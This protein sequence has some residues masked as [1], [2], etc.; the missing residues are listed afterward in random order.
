MCVCVLFKK[1]TIKEE[2][3]DLR[4]SKGD[5]ERAGGERGN[6]VY[7]VIIYKILKN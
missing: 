7:T 4:D 1:I 6:N 2:F 5:M 3:I